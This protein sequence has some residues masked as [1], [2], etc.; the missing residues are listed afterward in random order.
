MRAAWWLTLALGCSAPAPEEPAPAPIEAPPP[1]EA[2]APET[3]TAAPTRLVAFHPDDLAGDLSA[4]TDL[5]L[6][7]SPTDRLERRVG[8]EDARS[9]DEVCAGLD[10]TELATRARA[11]TTLRVSG[12][13]AA[14]HVGLGAFTGVGALE[15]ADLTLD[16]VTMGRVASLPSLRSLTLVRVTAGGEPMGVLG[17]LGV[18]SLTLRDLAEDSPLAGVIGQAPQLQRLALEGAWAGH[19]AMLVVP[20]ASRLR[21]VRLV[22]TRIGNFSLHQL[23][24]LV[25]LSEVSWQGSTFNDYSPLYVRDLPLQSF[26]CACPGLGDAGLKVLGRQK[27]LHT[28]V[29]PQSK[30]SGVGLTQLE[31]LDRLATVRIDRRDIGPEGMAALALLPALVDLSLAVSGPL[32]DP[33]LAHLGELVGLRR[34]ALV[35]P[36][37]DDRAMPQIAPLTRLERLDLGDTAISDTGLKALAGLTALTELELHHTRVTNRGLVHLAKLGRLQVLELDHTDLRDEGVAHLSGLTEMRALRLDK[38][39]ITDAAL[40]HLLGMHKLERLNLAETVVTD[41]GVALLRRLPALRSVNLAG[42]RATP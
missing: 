26:T 12:C 29:L 23:K 38:T 8:V 14:V 19:E 39:L 6:A 30:I 13:Q 41:A 28:L 5:D 34:L 37:L 42:T 33:T 4:V 16:G 11:V 10:L 25:E 27:R 1:E 2:P 7:F 32:L 15:L 35:M 31:K 3:P 24:P 9:Y 40:P 18:E 22:D 17:R 20:K 21:S 36:A